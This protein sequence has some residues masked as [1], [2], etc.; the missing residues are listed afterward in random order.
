MRFKW[1]GI[2]ERMHIAKFENACRVHLAKHSCHLQGEYQP[3]TDPSR[4]I[5][6]LY[7][8]QRYIER[9]YLIGGRKFDIRVYVLVLSVR[10]CL[11]L[12]RVKICTSVTSNPF[13]ART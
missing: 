13:H 9:P 10:H 6:E 2:L 11:L 4:E 12:R 1:T 3:V 7:V 8:V 5:P